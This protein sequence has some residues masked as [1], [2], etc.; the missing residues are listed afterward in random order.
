MVWASDPV[1]PPIVC[2]VYDVGDTEGQPFISMEY[3]DGEDLASLLRRIARPDRRPRRRRAA[4]R[5]DARE[6]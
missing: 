3:V 1:A 2:R 4:A 6:G 5:V